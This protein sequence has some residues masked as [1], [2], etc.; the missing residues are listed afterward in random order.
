MKQIIAIGDGPMS[1]NLVIGEVV[2]V[3]V[4]DSVLDESNK[5]DPRKLKLIARL[6][7]DWYCRSTDL[8]TLKRP[9]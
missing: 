3:H 6:G 7:G 8:F 9:Q 4:D 2:V 5:V 1:G